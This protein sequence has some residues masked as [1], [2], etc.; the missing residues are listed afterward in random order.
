MFW[1]NSSRKISKT[2]NKNEEKY[3]GTHILSKKHAI[4]KTKK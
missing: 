2:N 4:Q 1:I 3:I